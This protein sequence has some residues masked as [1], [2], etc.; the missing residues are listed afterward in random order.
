MGRGRAWEKR[1]GVLGTPGWRL[2][3]PAPSVVCS[4]PMPYL[5]GVHSSLAEVSGSGA[6]L[7]GRWNRPLHARIP[8]TARDPRTLSGSTPFHPPP[9]AES[10]GERPR[11]RRDDERGLQC[12]RDALRRHASAA[13]GC[14]Q[15]RPLAPSRGVRRPEAPQ[16]PAH[17]G[18]LVL[19]VSLLR[20]RLR[21]VALAPGEGVSRLFLKAQALLFGGYRDA[22]VCSPVSRGDAEAEASWGLRMIPT[23]SV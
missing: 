7:R 15:C 19:Q 13:P 21:K 1:P 11:R 5:I 18:C 10:A 3:N 2:H 22:L 8:S 9:N 23:P 6:G 20:L 12:L 4:A 17:R 16:P 14:G